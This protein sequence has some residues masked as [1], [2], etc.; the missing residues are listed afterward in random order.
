MPNGEPDTDL[1]HRRTTG[2][3]SRLSSGCRIGDSL[4]AG[5]HRARAPVR[6]QAAEDLGKMIVHERALRQEAIDMEGSVRQ[7]VI[8]RM[9]RGA[10]KRSEDLEKLRVGT[11][12]V[13]D[14][15][16]RRHNNLSARLD[17]LE[18]D[19]TRVGDK[20]TD[21]FLADTAWVSTKMKAPPA[22][23]PVLVCWGPGSGPLIYGVAAYDEG[24]GGSWRSGHDH[25]D[26]FHPVYRTRGVPEFWTRFEGV[27]R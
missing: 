1:G 13:L 24:S 18:K 8:E 11:D 15:A 14:N 2:K 27:E 9:G 21:A 6:G 25:V 10:A 17:A 20:A 22:G 5:K 19:V 3:R 23:V 26:A 7:E 4:H 16:L 12:V